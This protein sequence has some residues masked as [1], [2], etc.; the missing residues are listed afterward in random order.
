M[1]KNMRTNTQKHKSMCF[2]HAF[3][4]LKSRKDLSSIDNLM[5]LAI[6]CELSGSPSRNM[7]RE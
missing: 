3:L 5:N 2:Y 7:K 6:K 4:T 1:D